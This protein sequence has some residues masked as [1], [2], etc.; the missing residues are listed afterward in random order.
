[1]RLAGHPLAGGEWGMAGTVRCAGLPRIE[2][3]DYGFRF[4]FQLYKEGRCVTY[5]GCCC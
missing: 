4:D 2:L 5:D 3:R 1:M